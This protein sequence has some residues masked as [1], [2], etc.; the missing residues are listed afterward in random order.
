VVMREA[1][2]TTRMTD[3]VVLTGAMGKASW[4]VRLGNVWPG[5]DSV[6]ASVP[7]VA[8]LQLEVSCDVTVVWDLPEGFSDP[9]ATSN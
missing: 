2:T 8:C 3:D 4:K 5:E 1:C 7:G 6:V 9:N